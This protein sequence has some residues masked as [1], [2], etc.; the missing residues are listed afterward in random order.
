MRSAEQELRNLFD[1]EVGPNS[2]RNL[3]FGGV[4][5][6]VIVFIQDGEKTVQWWHEIIWRDETQFALF[7]MGINILITEVTLQN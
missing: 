3:F 1:N 7:A 6:F 2:A 5:C 4:L